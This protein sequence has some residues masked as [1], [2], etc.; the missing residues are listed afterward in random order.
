MPTRNE[1]KQLARLRL[2]EAETLYSARLYDGCAYL[3]GYVVEF[4]LKARICKLLGLNEYPDSGKLKNAYA[5][6][7]INQL[8]I[9][10][11]LQSKLDPG[12]VQLFANWS[13]ATPWTPERRYMP[14][15][16]TNRATAK[17]ILD[18]VRSTPDGVLRWIMRYW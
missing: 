8:L 10:S 7:D 9:L 18:A 4:A 16:T 11:G 12:N 3:C 13:L 6:H 14:K 15:G 5:V 1:F 2:K 17:D